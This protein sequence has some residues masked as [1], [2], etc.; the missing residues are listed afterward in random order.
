MKKPLPREQALLLQRINEKRTERARIKQKSPSHPRKKKFISRDE[1]KNWPQLPLPE[2]FCLSNYD[3]AVD[4]ISKVKNSI[5]KE[6][7]IDFDTIREVDTATAIMLAAELEVMKIKSK[8]S[9]MVAHDS[10]WFPEVRT[11]LVQM[12]FLQL[13]SAIPEIPLDAE[14]PKNHI[15]VKFQSGHKLIGDNIVQILEKL[16]KNIPIKKFSADLLVHL[17]V[18]ISEAITNTYQHAYHGH[19]RNQHNKLNRWWISAS[20]NKQTHEI[21]VVC[22]D[23]GATIPKT[24]ESSLFPV[25]SEGKIIFNTIKERKSST[26]DKNRGKGL[27]ELL[28]LIDKNKQGTLRIYSGK[29]LVEFKRSKNGENTDIS[30]ELPRKMEGTLVEWSIIPDRSTIAT[31]TH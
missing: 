22:Y 24:I 26:K 4:A 15:F 23:R 9:R 21:R 17:C 31:E 1:C 10:H 16:Q 3:Q 13:L 7:Y 5:G 6:I 25:F 11:L 12:G 30:E 14:P 27:S 8:K 29:G 20:I 18:G 28:R 19:H 2:N